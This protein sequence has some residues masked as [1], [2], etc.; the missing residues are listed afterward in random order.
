[1][2]GVAHRLQVAESANW[3]AYAAR[4]QSRALPSL[5]PRGWAEATV[6]SSCTCPATG[7]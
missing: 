5:A 6:P 7:T 2:Y 3:G 1:L 4:P